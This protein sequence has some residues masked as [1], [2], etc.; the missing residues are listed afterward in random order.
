MISNKSFTFKGS[1]KRLITADLSYK[2]YE[3]EVSIAIFAH[4]FKG[5]K[6]W[7]AWPLAAQIFALKGIP[8]FKFNFSHN[9]T[10]P[11]HLSDFS[12]LDAFGNNTIS[13]ELEDLA[14]VCDFIEQKSAS[15]EFKWNG[16]FFLIGHS[17]GAA[18]SLLFAS[19]D[20]RITKCVS[21]A[22]V[23][24]LHSYLELDDPIKWQRE[25][26]CYIDNSRTKQKMPIKFSFFEDLVNHREAYNVITQIEELKQDLLI[27]HGD[28]D[29]V[30]SKSDAD[31]MY[32][33][34]GHS[35]LLTVE[36]ANHTFNTVHPL[37]EKKIPIA[38]AQV[39]DESIEFLLM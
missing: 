15:F 23:S 19:G 37:K 9:G 8:F 10:T 16:Q 3:Q 13:K 4:G 36:K 29:V 38:F 18:T 1:E 31:A 22:G 35:I 30:V 32:N 27:V 7:G 25:G 20:D 34:V 2:N 24:N 39:L 6:D 11:E 33:S 28:E 14:K 26:V 12:D 17:R 21:W 5:F